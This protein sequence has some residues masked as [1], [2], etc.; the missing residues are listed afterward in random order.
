M[1]PTRGRCYGN[2]KLAAAGY[3]VVMVTAHLTRNTATLLAELW[4]S[5][6]HAGTTLSQH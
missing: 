4:A 5:V 3:S 2:R 6:C 1:Y